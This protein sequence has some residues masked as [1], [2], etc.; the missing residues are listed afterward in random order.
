MEG[1]KVKEAAD[2]WGISAKEVK[3]LCKEGAVR[4]AEKTA[5]GWVI[6]YGTPNPENG[7]EN[8]NCDKT[9]IKKSKPIGR[10]IAIILVVGAVLGFIAIM[11][12]G[13]AE[14]VQELNEEAEILLKCEIDEDVFIH[15]EEFD[16][17]Y[18]PKQNFVK[19]HF[20]YNDEVNAFKEE[21]ERF[22]QQQAK[23]LEAKINEL[24]PCTKISSYEQYVEISETISEMTLLNEVDFDMRVKEY[25]SNYEE[26]EQYADSFETLCKD[27]EKVCY[28]C[29]GSGRCSCEFCGGSGKRLVTWYS[30]GD[31][32]ETSYSSYECTS[33]DGRGK[34]TC[35][36]CA[37]EGWYYH[38]D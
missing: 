23:E 16:R 33:C 9:E 10:I 22:V 20:K 29:N 2:I 6:P 21:A 32:G 26:F 3:R 37:G 24:K 8:S 36:R 11:I 13:T 18:E 38:F 25:V 12:N 28:K 4:G 7:S 30:E 5:S 31:W 34:F 15:I 1:L 27:Y 19:K 35:T 17:T 14:T